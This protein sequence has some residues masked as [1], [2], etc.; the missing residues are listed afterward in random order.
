MKQALLTEND[1]RQF[2]KE[3]ILC[4]KTLTKQ[5]LMA[6]FSIPD[7]KYRI[8]MKNGLPFTVKDKRKYFKFE[9]VK[10]WLEKFG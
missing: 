9:E 10:D 7:W 1:V 6:C 4:K 2:I 8:Y 3:S 5:E